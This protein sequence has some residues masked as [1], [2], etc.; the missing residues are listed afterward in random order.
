[1]TEYLDLYDDCGR[2]TGMRIQ[3]GQPLPAGCRMLLISIMTVNSAGEILLTR[4]APEKRYAGRWEITAGCVQAGETAAEGAVR[5]LREETGIAAELA[6]L[7]DCGCTI[8]ADFVHAFFLVHR[9]IPAE[10]IRLQPGETDGAQWV[11]PQKLLAMSEDGKTV[12]KHNT[13]IL[14]HY[15]EVFRGC[16]I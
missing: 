12:W 1:M 4:R 11:T 10:Q 15:S 2:P 6:D 3:R 9:D 13:L 16:G 7:T 8:H 14:R 5:E